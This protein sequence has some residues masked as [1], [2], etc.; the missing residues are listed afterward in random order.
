MFA[1]PCRGRVAG[2]AAGYFADLLFGDPRR[3]HPVALF[4]GGAAALERLTYADSRRA[5]ALHAGALLAAL[6]VLG[7]TVERSAMRHG[8]GWTAA[9]TVL[10]PS[11]ASSVHTLTIVRLATEDSWTGIAPVTTRPAP[12]R[13]RRPR[14]A[15]CRANS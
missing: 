5:G 11:T 6:G 7:V 14:Y 9:A 8:P 12:P 10:N 4:G 1:T 15:A 2:I 13:A 3:W